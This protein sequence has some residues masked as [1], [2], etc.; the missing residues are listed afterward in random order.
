MT[1]RLCWGEVEAEAERRGLHAG[2][3]AEV[4]MLRGYSFLHRMQRWWLAA[5]RGESR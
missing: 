2:L 3:L 4:N 5:V 1:S